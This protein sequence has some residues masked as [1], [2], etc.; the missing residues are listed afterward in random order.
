MDIIEE[1]LP[2]INNHDKF[3][4]STHI[5][6]DGDAIGAQLALYSFLTDLG[7]KVWAVNKDPVPYGYVFL[8]FSDVISSKLPQEPFEILIVVDVA[9]FTRTGSELSKVLLPEKAIINIDHHV[10]N[11]RFGQYNW[12]DDNASATSELIYKLIKQH[13]MN[14]GQERATCLYTG[15]V[16]DTG[17]FRFA[18]TTPETHR[19]V[20]ELITE[21]V[22]PEKVSQ[23]VYENLPS[24]RIKLLG[25]VLSTL[26]VSLDG[27]VAW[28]RVTQDMYDSTGTNQEDTEN[29]IDHVKSVNTV[30]IALFFVELKSGKTKVSF[31][32]KNEFDVSKIAI[33]FGGGGHQKAAGCTL[34][35]S[36]DE[37][38]KTIVANIQRE[39]AAFQ[40]TN[41]SPY[42]P[43]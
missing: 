41:I 6:P 23:S 38:E 27:K 34:D 17:S 4:I 20:A 18:N 25:L 10:T 8:P 22:S 9:T 40:A 35:T 2:V 1:I 11:D 26:Q 12:I 14:I 28:I 43:L 36:V 19:I 5:S 33:Y 42:K 32:S 30:E 39:L 37:T 7:K 13:G 31:R 16:T 21:G 29:F 24:S 3:V 15:I